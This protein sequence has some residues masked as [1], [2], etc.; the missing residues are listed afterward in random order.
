MRPFFKYV[1][2]TIVQLIFIFYYI[3]NNNKNNNNYNNDDNDD[4]K[5]N[6]EEM[7][8]ELHYRIQLLQSKKMKYNEWIEFNNKNITAK[9]NNNI[10]NISIFEDLL[11]N[12]NFINRAYKY[13]EFIG[14]TW[15]DIV[16]NTNEQLIFTKYSTDKNLLLNANSLAE[17]SIDNKSTILYYWIEPD[18]TNIY[19]RLGH[20]VKWKDPIS[21]IN[22]IIE[23]SYDIEILKDEYTYKDFIYKKDIFFIIFSALFITFIIHKYENKS[24]IK[25]FA[26]ITIS[27]IF[28]ILYLNRKENINSPKTELEKLNNIN[29]NILS[30]SFLSGINTFILT[31]LNNEN[32][33]QLYKESAI[34]F[35]IGIIL[36]LDTLMRVTN[37][38]TT[39]DVIRIRLSNQ[40][41]F[42]YVIIINIFI[43]LNYYIILFPNKLY[44]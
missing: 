41:K 15:N 2:F 32:K 9:I 17:I 33:F 25:S 21:N 39:N 31:S 29:I 10:M 24:N 36:L 27:N 8:K 23:I 3:F 34:Q 19:K 28:I 40:L 42:D 38:E 44:F 11:N 6:I 18:S 7:Y 35:S 20:F 14:L 13:K 4:K 22:G 26:F 1:I 5:K 43:I 16:K 30:L 37:Y 12:D